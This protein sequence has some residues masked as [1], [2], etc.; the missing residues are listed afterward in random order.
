MSIKAEL[1]FTEQLLKIG[2]TLDGK[3]I[4]ECLNLPDGDEITLNYIPRVGESIF[5]SNGN[6]FEFEIVK[7]HHLVFPNFV[8]TTEGHKVRLLLKQIPVMDWLET[9]VI[10]S[11]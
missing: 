4:L 3:P 10:W 9:S 8:D 1:T 6:N 5:I 2:S 11:R 7:V